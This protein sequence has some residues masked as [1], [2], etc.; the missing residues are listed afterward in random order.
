MVRLSSAG[1]IGN[2]ICV[3]DG[4]N[5]NAPKIVQ[6]VAREKESERYNSIDMTGQHTIAVQ[7]SQFP[8]VTI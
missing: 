3:T 5:K 2:F 8:F 1:T 7:A 6:I 4:R